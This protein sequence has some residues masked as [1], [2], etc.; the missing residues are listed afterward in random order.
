MQRVL[1]VAT[2][3]GLSASFLS[4]VVEV[5]A[6]RKQLRELI[7]GGLWPQTVLRLGYGSPMQPRDGTS[8]AWSTTVRS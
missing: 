2:A 1:L 4:Q 6:T 3:A 5:P 7:V 8:R